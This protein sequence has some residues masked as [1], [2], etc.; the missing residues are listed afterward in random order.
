MTSVPGS[1]QTSTSS[2]DHAASGPGAGATCYR[3]ETPHPLD[4]WVRNQSG[5]VEITAADVTETSV[6]VVPNDAKGTDLAE[7]T[8]VQLSEDARRLRIDVPDR[9]MLRQPALEIIVTVPTGSSIDVETATAEVSTRGILDSATVTTAS[10]DVSLSH[11]GGPLEVTTASGDIHIGRGAGPVQVRTASGDLRLDVS[12]IEA[13]VQTASG[14]V[15]I[16][17]L[18]GDLT[19]RSASGDV[20]ISSAGGGSVQ[21]KTMS[22]DVVIGVA[23]GLLLWLDV[24]S[25]SGDVASQLGPGES[26]ADG[27]ADREPDLRISAST[28]SGDV[29]L[30]H[31][32]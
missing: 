15:M 24:N 14:D 5:T 30:R 19:A 8:R 32:R 18:S 29:L 3:F 13:S 7:R 27:D 26:N 31:G 17:R 20:I 22:G 1:S 10:A 25:L 16:G 4:V 9:K 6:E 28:M 11:V 23:R 2:A 12:E 21:A